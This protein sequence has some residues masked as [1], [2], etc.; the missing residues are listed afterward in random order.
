MKRGRPESLAEVAEA[1]LEGAP[2]HL[3]LNNFLDEFY[4]NPSSEAF[5]REPSLMEPSRGEAGKINDAYLAAVAEELCRK[6]ELDAPLW[7]TS[8][9]RALRSP[10]FACTLASLRAVL[11]RE[12]PPAFRCR[13]LFVSENALSRA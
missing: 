4:L 2:F 6:F 5:T 13:N 1:T 7:A 11:I 8:S 3:A 9:K 12:S 10:W